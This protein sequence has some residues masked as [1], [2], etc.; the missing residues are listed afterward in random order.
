MLV[1]FSLRNSWLEFASISDR[2][3]PCSSKCTCFANCPSHPA[4]KMVSWDRQL[5]SDIVLWEARP[6][7]KI[8]DANFQRHLFQQHQQDPPKLHPVKAF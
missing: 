2:E 7:L 5:L 8:S 1:R 6:K 4:P 3:L